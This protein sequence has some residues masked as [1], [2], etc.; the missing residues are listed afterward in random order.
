MRK[1]A[2]ALSKGGVG[3]STTAVKKDDLSETS[4]KLIDHD[5]TPNSARHS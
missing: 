3:K 1:L 5:S 4:Q 2:I